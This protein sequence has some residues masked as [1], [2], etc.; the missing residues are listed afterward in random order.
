MSSLLSLFGSKIN[1]DVNFIN[2]KSTVKEGNVAPG[3]AFKQKERRYN[4]DGEELFS[5]SS[6]EEELQPDEVSEE[7]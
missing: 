5:D 1:T 7:E 2:E 3:R 4:E 6:D